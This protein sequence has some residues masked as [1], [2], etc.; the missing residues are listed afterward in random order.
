MDNES[1]VVTGKGN[2]A[3][4]HKVIDVTSDEVLEYTKRARL[5]LAEDMAKDGVPT[6]RD[7]RV[8]LELLND[9]DNQSL[10]SKRL[11]L[12]DKAANN[13]N[14]VALMA[15]RIRERQTKLIEDSVNGTSPKRTMPEP[16]TALLP[17]VQL[18]QDEFNCE[19]IDD[20][21]QSF[22]DRHHSDEDQ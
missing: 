3:Q 11:D 1:N 14:E 20:D 16:N 2:L 17:K 15:I 19:I 8:F 7:R 13:D 18:D 6:G 21:F 12:D 5:C 10:S 4:P 9:L 22:T